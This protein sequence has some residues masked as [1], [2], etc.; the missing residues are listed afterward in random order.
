M[1][2]DADEALEAELQ[3]LD[4]RY[5]AAVAEL[6]ERGLTHVEAVREATW[7][8][9]YYLEERP[10]LQA[11]AQ[12]RYDEH[13][14]ELAKFANEFRE[15]NIA[16]VSGRRSRMAQPGHLP[17]SDLRSDRRLARDLGMPKAAVE[18]G[19]R[20]APPL[21]VPDPTWEGYVI[22]MF[23]EELVGDDAPP[24][25]A[26]PRWPGWFVD[27]PKGPIAVRA[28][29]IIVRHVDSEA[30]LEARRSRRGTWAI[31]VRGLEVE[32]SVDR[33][34]KVLRGIGLLRARYNLPGPGRP[35]KWTPGE[36]A[37][38]RDREIAAWRKRTGSHDEQCPPKVLAYR[39]GKTESGHPWTLEYYYELA[40]R[41]KSEA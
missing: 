2:G 40:R 4:D 21:S 10:A 36:F 20:H 5:T 8:R 35:R 1:T 37:R 13:Q 3:Q 39:M 27:N 33:A 9:I 31:A 15:H 30:W 38:V 24:V 16:L 19:L 32:R 22:E 34:R 14:A 7:A 41:M 23:G 12:R 28:W 26:P 6:K 29:R 17:V 11:L 25:D 18:R